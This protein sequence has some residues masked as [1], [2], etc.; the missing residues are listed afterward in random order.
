FDPLLREVAGPEPRYFYH[1]HSYAVLE[2][3]GDDVLG[4]SRYDESFASIVGRGSVWGIQFHPEK[5]QEDGLRI[6][7]N[8]ARV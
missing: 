1:V 8:F 2:D 4:R 7:R 3:D 6:L 5:S